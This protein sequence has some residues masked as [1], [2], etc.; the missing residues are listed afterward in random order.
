MGWALAIVRPCSWRSNSSDRS[1]FDWRRKKGH[2]NGA[3]RS[4]AHYLKTYLKREGSLRLTSL[5][6]LA[7]VMK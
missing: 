6:A 3:P 4:T 2:A 1:R 5:M 7:L